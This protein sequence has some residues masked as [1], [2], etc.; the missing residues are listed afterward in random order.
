MFQ[1]IDS[2]R[3]IAVLL[4]VVTHLFVYFGNP[5][6]GFVEPGLVGSKGVAI[7]FVLTSYVLMYSLQRLKGADDKARQTTKS[8]SV[9]KDHYI[10]H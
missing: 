3:T 5:N 10:L 4:V 1:I 6:D 7:F 2:W 9:N 8:K